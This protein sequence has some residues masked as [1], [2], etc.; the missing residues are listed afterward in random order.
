MYPKV[1]SPKGEPTKDWLDQAFAPLRDYLEKHH[2]NEAEQMMT[3]MMFMG[4]EE[5]LFHYKNS[6]TRAYIVF[7]QSGNL[8]SLMDS[9]LEYEFEWLRGTPVERPPISERFIHP[10]VEKW[11]ASHLSLDEDAKYGEDV[12]TFLQ[13]LWGPVVNYQFDDL[14]AKYPILLRGN[15]PAYCLN[16]YPSAFDK[17]ISFMFIGDEIVERRCTYKQY[18]DFRDAERDFT[19]EGWRVI[20]LFREAFDAELPSFLHRMIEI[21]DRKIGTNYGSL[22]RLK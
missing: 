13:E 22:R 9:A 12:R 16:I 14:L 3:F 19:I 18:E 17:R 2:P 20:S 11:I 7:D 1:D 4:N 8:D 5:G 21:A 10:N 6:I 15:Q